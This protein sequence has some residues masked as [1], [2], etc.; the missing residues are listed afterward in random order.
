MWTRRTHGLTPVMMA[1]LGGHM[2]TAV[3]L[4]LSGADLKRRD[5]RGR[6]ALEL[7]I[8]ASNRETALSLILI[9]TGK[10]TRPARAAAA[11]GCSN[12]CSTAPARTRRRLR[13]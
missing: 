5:A 13:W 6:T 4:A 12:G 9:A 1:V 11:C 8:L 7:A 10:F 2:E 3:Q